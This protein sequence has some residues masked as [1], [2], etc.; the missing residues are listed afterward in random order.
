MTYPIG[1][2]QLDASAG[3]WLF[4]D[5]DDFFGGQYREQDS[6]GSYQSHVSYTFRPG[7]W[8]AADVTYYGGGTSSLDGKRNP[9]RQSNTR[10]GATLSVPLMQGL[11]VKLSYS[12]GAVVRIGGDFRSIGINFQYA[13]F[14]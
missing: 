12:E 11:S 10:V 2:W 13:W 9:D 5:N 1:R 7:L 4:Q 6:I 14:D 8:L 3:L